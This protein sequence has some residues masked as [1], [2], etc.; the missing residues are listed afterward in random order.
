MTKKKYFINP[1]F[2][3][4]LWTTYHEDEYFY[5]EFAGGTYQVAPKEA[6]QFMA[7]RKYCTGYHSIEDISK[8]SQ[9]SVD[10]IE[11][12]VKSLAGIGLLR[13]DESDI[14]ELTHDEIYDKLFTACGLWRDQ[15]ENFH[16][17]NNFLRGEYGLQVFQGSLLES[18]HYIKDFPLVIKSAIDSTSDENMKTILKN[19]YQQE[20]GHEKFI[21]STLKNTGLSQQEVVESTP[22]VSTQNIINLMT[23]L[24]S[25]FP[26]AIFLIAQLVETDEYDI[27]EVKLTKSTITKL[28][29]IPEH[30]LDPYFDHIKLDYEMR[31]FALMKEN[32]QYI[33]L[34]NNNDIDFILNSLHDIKH[35]FDLQKLEIIDY[36]SKEGNYFPRQKIDYFGI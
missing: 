26:F 18:Y 13:Q 27:D 16:I 20:L 22:L 3:H 32:K 5:L 33:K 8:K 14:S 11:D 17:M 36:Y 6:A 2:I 4:N 31:H 15:I 9:I 23:N 19:Y 1:K 7:I 10:Q 34:Q 25:K 35:S 24:V 28:Y 12:I 30:S 21:I 29:S